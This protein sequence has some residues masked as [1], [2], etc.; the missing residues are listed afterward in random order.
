MASEAQADLGLDA[1]DAGAE[2]QLKSKE[3]QMLAVPRKYAMLSGVVKT[4]LESDISATEA[5]VDVTA[6]ILAK[7]VEYLTHHQ[8]VDP[9]IPEKPLRSKI[10]KEVCSQAWDAE[11]I[12]KIGENRQLL[13]DVILAANYLDIKPLLHLGCAKVASLIKG[14]PINKIKNILDPNYVETGDAPAAAATEEK[15]E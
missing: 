6:P 3:G 10:M 7:I 11:F 13:Y 14:V 2:I 4:A 1:P 9:G 5:P 15:K 8:G 12:D